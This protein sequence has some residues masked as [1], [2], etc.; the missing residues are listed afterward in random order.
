MRIGAKVPNSGSLPAERGIAAMAAELER[1]GFES[2]WVSDHVVMTERV[3]SRYPF[4]ADGKVT[5]APDTPY[6]DAMIAL[7]SIATATER[8]VIGTAVLVLPQRHP[9]VLAKQAASV[10][11]MSGG[12]LALGLGAGWLAEEFEALNV[13]FASRAG[14][15]V[16]WVELLRACWT[17]APDAYEGAHYSLPAGV[18]SVPIPA[19]P[20]QLLV[21]G[22]S[23]AARRRAGAIGDGWLAHQ[24]ATAL[25]VDELRTGIAVSREAA[26]EAGRDPDALWTTLRIIDS[27]T[28]ADVVADALPPLAEAG[29]DEVVV[30]IDWATSGDAVD[31]F[32]ALDAARA[33]LGR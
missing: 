23:E 2:L 9:V 22:H 13:P 14:R 26:L 18:L 17:G 20:V 27:A 16:E 12:R 11:V 29:V 33:S 15:F 5:W 7:A 1:A 24:S 21:G 10:D 32:G 4:A 25:D 30:D 28:R 6:F 8:A 19:H 3:D 31:A